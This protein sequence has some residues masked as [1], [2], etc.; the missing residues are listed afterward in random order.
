MSSDNTK[1]E[2]NTDS[3]NQT[4][5][6]ENKGVLA[7]AMNF[8]S[9]AA[10]A[11]VEKV[12][13]VANVAK[14]KILG[15]ST[16]EEKKDEIKEAAVEKKDEIVEKASEKKEELKEKADEL[17]KDA[18]NKKDQL[19]EKA[20]E[21]KDEMMEKKEEIKS[22]AS[23]KKE[24]LMEKAADLK[25]TVFEKVSE[26]KD[27]MVGKINTLKDTVAEGVAN[28]Q[29][30][31]ET[32]E[33]PAKEESKEQSKE[34]DSDEEQ[35]EA[36]RIEK[37]LGHGPAQKV[38]GMRVSQ[39]HNGPHLFKKADGTTHHHS[40]T[41]HF[42]IKHDDHEKTA[43]ELALAEKADA[44]KLKEVT[45]APKDSKAFPANYQHPIPKN[46]EN[47]KISYKNQP[48]ALNFQPPSHG[49]SH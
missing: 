47:A 11:V 14:E 23:E 15:D 17:K 37:K 38:G 35:D 25:D 12:E 27:V 33:A 19:A 28:A 18:I 22:D 20:S 16:A 46:D 7:S 32:K 13:E 34:A 31:S 48:V 24:T 21:K 42:E 44:L 30:P 3:S 29:Q 49:L 26:M 39:N 8:I 40:G 9:G 1:I 10:S 45:S 43:T 6:Q 4:N 2:S 36:K 5:D 41:T